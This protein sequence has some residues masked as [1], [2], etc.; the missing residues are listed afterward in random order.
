MFLIDLLWL[1][2]IYLLWWWN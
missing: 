2:C 1:M